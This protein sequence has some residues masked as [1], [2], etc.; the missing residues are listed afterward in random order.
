[1]S[2][3]Y[4]NQND[5]FTSQGLVLNPEGTEWVR[6]SSPLPIANPDASPA[7]VAAFRTAHSVKHS[8]PLPVADDRS[9]L[10]QYFGPVNPEAPSYLVEPDLQEAQGG[11]QLPSNMYQEAGGGVYF[12]DTNEPVPMVGRPGVLPIAMTPEGVKVVMPKMLDIVGNVMGNVAAPKVAAKVGEMVLG[13]GA[14]RTA[15]EAKAA[16]PFYS[17]LEHTVKDAKP[18]TDQWLGYLRNQPGVKQEELQYVLGNLPKGQITKTQLED[19]VKQNKVELKEKVLSDQPAQYDKKTGQPDRTY[20]EGTPF[21]PTKYHQ[22]QLPGGE[23]YKEV[24]LSLPEKKINTHGWRAEKDPQGNKNDWLIYNDKDE[25]VAMRNAS[26][27]EQAI[28]KAH[29]SL[30]T[31]KSVNNFQAPHFDE[32]GTNL[33]AHIRMNDRNIEGKKVLHIEEVQSD[34]HQKGREQGYKGEKEKLQPEFDKIEQK[35]LDSKDEAIM[36]QPN[37]KD[38]LK[39]AVD[40]KIINQDEAKTYKRFTDIENGKP[41]PDFPFK[42]NWE[43]LALKH[44]VRHAAENNYDAISWEHGNAQ[45]LRYPDELR[46]QVKKIEWIPSETVK[47]EK[48]ILVYPTGE[49]VPMNIRINKDGV[50]V[51]GPAQAKGKHLSEVI[52][53]N[54]SQQ[55]LEK[56]EG[57]IDAKDFVMGAEGMKAAYDVRLPNK[58]NEIGK[59]YGSKVEQKELQTFKVMR[60]G[61]EDWRVIG[62]DNKGLPRTFKT[63][64]LAK[65]YAK[66]KGGTNVH[67]FPLTPALRTK[68]M[69]EGFPLFSSS[70]VLVPVDYNPFERK[71]PKL[72]PVSHIPVFE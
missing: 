11:L 34:L 39:M 28:E 70:P 4:D 8:N 71:E 57:T 19:I 17:Q 49:P 46:K 72:T 13:S 25:V 40:K 16:E 60:A 42:N 69:N 35:I 29:I 10:N 21:S 62:N 44:I 61:P 23:N 48:Q 9:A 3:I 5:Y 65:E 27:A 53:K 12:N 31:G 45:A 67:Y 14:V 63:E 36:G 2:D 43:E 51:L 33:L 38:A 56:A 68:A 50:V 32:H 15:Q 55:I 26:N 30:A 54:M 22:Y 47:G 1:M 24:L 37:I 59:K 41:V 64:E 6:A 7:D 52:G 18:S 58:I 66:E 20:P